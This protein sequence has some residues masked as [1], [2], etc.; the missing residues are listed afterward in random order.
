ML[1]R[2]PERTQKVG[3]FAIS[4]HSVTMGDSIRSEGKEQ[5]QEAAENSRGFV[6][7]PL[8]M[9][10]ST[11]LI[12]GLLLF[13]CFVT[14]VFVRLEY[15]HRLSEQNKNA[16]S[17]DISN[18]ITMQELRLPK[19]LKPTSYDLKIKVYL[20]FYVDF[21]TSKNLTTEGELDI[22]I[23]V[24]EPT[25][26]IILN[27]KDIGILSEKCQAHAD[28][29]HVP[30]TKIT[31]DKRLE[32]VA[33]VLEKTLRAN[34]NVKLKVIFTGIVNDML[35]GLYRTTYYDSQRNEKIAAVT[36]FESA[37]A[38]LMV[39][40]FDEPEYK[41]TWNVTVIHPKGTTALSNGI[42]ISETT[43]PN[44]KW[45]VSTF[46]Q[47]PIM[48]SYL[49]AIFV[50]EYEFDEAHTN[51]GVRFR[52]WSPPGNADE[53][54]RGLKAAIIFMETLEKYF[55]I[56][57]VV[58]KQDF[59]AVPDFSAGAMENWGLTTYRPKLILLERV[60]AK[61]GWTEGSVIAHELLHQWLGN[62][63]TMKW[64]DELW[65][66]EGF[67]RYFQKMILDDNRNMRISRRGLLDS[68]DYSMAL[69]SLAAS[70]PLS[71][72]IDMP[73][74]I[75]E[76]Y[77]GISYDRGACIIS[78]IHE[79]VG[80]ENFRRA[81][82]HYLKKFSFKNTRANDLWQSFDDVVGG[83]IGPDG[84]KLNMIDFGSQ[85]SKQMGF[86]LVTVEQLN[87]TT[88]K[89]RQERYMKVPHAVE[90][91]K[92]RSSNYGYKWDVPLWYQWGNEKMY[93]KWLKKDEPLY[94]QME[95][96]DP[97][98]VINA[99]RRA[100]FIQN[101]DDHGWKKIAKQLVKNHEIY[102]PCTRYTIIRDAFAAAL[103][104]RVDYKT[105]FELLQYLNKEKDLLV[106]SAASSAFRTMKIFF[107]G[108]RENQLISLFYN[109]LVRKSYNS[110]YSKYI[111][112]EVETVENG[113]PSTD[114]SPQYHMRKSTEEESSSLEMKI[115]S[116]LVESFCEVNSNNCSS[117][118]R[119]LFEKEVLGR[120]TKSKKASQC[121]RISQHFRGCTYCQGVKQ[122]GSAAI[123]KIKALYDIEEDE[124]EKRNLISGMTCVENIEELKLA[125]LRAIDKNGNIQTQLIPV[126][127]NEVARNPLSNEFL[128][129]FLLEHWEE[130]YDRLKD[131]D[132]QL[133]KVI[134]ACLRSV[135]SNIQIMLVKHFR[136]LTPTFQQ[137]NIINIR[138]EEAQ[139]RIMWLKKHSKKL[140]EFFESTL[141][142][143]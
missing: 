61:E 129:N 120:C 56:D 104:D 52:V 138:I 18:L 97:P 3:S 22:D 123:T 41:A 119:S 143:A 39:P 17:K 89:I 81:M 112:R 24:L 54:K 66:K 11:I 1:L 63:V 113:G 125:L 65:L 15:E 87:S 124:E 23:V 19:N 10:V 100:Y 28:G 76:S 85:W 106:V 130:I 31:D 62:L 7:T 46:R 110:I 101:Y 99:D 27:S 140:I 88:L 82:T 137:F 30:I 141:S 132:S 127:F 93:H 71:S 95:S 90:K 25:N 32:K 118:F 20:P 37:E 121:V 98:I 64:W 48:S 91:Q 2:G 43:E 75:R 4:G 45:K 78:M 50:S 42:E 117:T 38:R 69:D 47:T 13:S 114:K 115:A 34:Q 35:K 139:H 70:R 128:T 26:T 135:H 131:Y 59:V 12:V 80:K 109:K 21:P 96:S 142:K 8:L 60:S 126:V 5:E 6:C 44:G 49:L 136:E 16:Q 55:G 53:R 58:M 40:C 86:P 68:F 67:A 72:V 73:V 92:Y 133:Q 116:S 79:L 103:I 102:T 14:Y 108:M 57:D 83:T 111:S 74:E 84:M 94:I 51:R 134:S 9:L 36:Q 122:L 105:V 29:V 33:F 107:G 77:D